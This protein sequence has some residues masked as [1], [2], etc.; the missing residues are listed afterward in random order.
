LSTCWTIQLQTEGQEQQGQ[1]VGTD[2]TN[3]SSYVKQHTGVALV[4]SCSQLRWTSGAEQLR[5]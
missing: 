1:S 3:R 5:R 4:L 2:T